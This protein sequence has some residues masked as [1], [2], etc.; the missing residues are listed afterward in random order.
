[1]EEL[2]EALNARGAPY[3]EAAAL[4][5]IGVFETLKTISRLA[6]HRYARRSRTDTP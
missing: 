4:H 6:C 1:V 3:F 5:G 2:T